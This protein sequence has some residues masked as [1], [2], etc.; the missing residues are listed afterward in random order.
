MITS[1]LSSFEKKRSLT[2]KQPFLDLENGVFNRGKHEGERVGDVL[3][4]DVD[5]LF[6]L[7]EDSS[8]DENSKIYIECFLEDNL[9]IG[10][11]GG[12]EE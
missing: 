2:M 6:F 12:K 11:R 3:H 4:S 1:A 10:F 9:D 8:I 7:V 5:Y